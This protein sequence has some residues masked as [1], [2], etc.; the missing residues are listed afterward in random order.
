MVP[1]QGEKII[2]GRVPAINKAATAAGPLS[3]SLNTN[4]NS[5]SSVPRRL[6]ALAIAIA[7][8]FDHCVFVTSSIVSAYCRAVI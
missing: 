7:W 6:N 4:V 8:I 3:F 2:I 1:A 5:V